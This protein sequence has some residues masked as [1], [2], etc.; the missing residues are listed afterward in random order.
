[1]ERVAEPELMVEAEQVRAYA[2]A[3]FA[4]PHGRFVELLRERCPLLGASGRAVD[5]GCG[6]ADVTIRV[7]RSLDA[8]SIDGVDGSE[9]MLDAGRHAVDEAKLGARV[10]LHHVLLP[11]AAPHAAGY[12]LVFSNSLLH[13]LARP[14][15]L[16]ETALE[17]AAA[18]AFIFVMDLMRPASVEAARA[19]IDSYAADEPPVMQRDFYN[20]L[21]AAYSPDEV[22]GQLERC[23]LGQFAV[24][25]VSDRHFVVFGRLH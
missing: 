12:E 19:L 14:E 16:W 4:V 3:D 7:A 5:L 8:W 6:P 18:N 1:M 23:G 17:W 22:R 20:S 15:V 11:A 21:L 13:H 2:A 25:V 10:R 24:E 9:R